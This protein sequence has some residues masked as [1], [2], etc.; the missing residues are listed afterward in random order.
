MFYVDLDYFLCMLC[1]WLYPTH[2]QLGVR[3]FE[4]PTGW[5]FFGNLMDS[6]E[7]G[8]EVCHG[9]LM[10]AS[11]EICRCAHKCFNLVA[12]RCAIKYSAMLS[13]QAK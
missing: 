1:P 5:K 2:R 7:L 4:T 9:G 12:M 10:C 11:R 8:G 13:N 3:F 6:K